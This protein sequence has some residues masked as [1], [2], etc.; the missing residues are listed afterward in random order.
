MSDKWEHHTVFP[1]RS[2]DSILPTM[3]YGRAAVRG[4]DGKISE[5]LVK[6]TLRARNLPA[7]IK[8]LADFDNTHKEASLSI[9]QEYDYYESYLI[10]WRDISQEELL[11]VSDLMAADATRAA[12]YDKQHLERLKKEH[13]DWFTNDS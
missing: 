1:S 5:I 13:P 3:D 12:D 6:E 11:E 8:Q 4:K 7:V 2:G 9:E 10:G